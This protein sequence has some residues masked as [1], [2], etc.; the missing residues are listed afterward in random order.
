MTPVVV[1][2]YLTFLHVNPAKNRKHMLWGNPSCLT[3]F[4]SVQCHIW[5]HSCLN[6]L[7]QIVQS[8]SQKR[9]GTDTE[10]DKGDTLEEDFAGMAGH[11]QDEYD[12]ESILK[13]VTESSWMKV[14]NKHC[15]SQSAALLTFSC[16]SLKK[17]N[18]A[19]IK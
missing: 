9:D 10:V 14:L 18:W 4:C 8:L 19:N 7:I 11:L 3:L 1:S 5:D 12:T 2:G 13:F 6:F 16:V 15:F 17:L